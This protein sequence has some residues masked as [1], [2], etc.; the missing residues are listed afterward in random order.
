MK[1]FVKKHWILIIS[2]IY[3]IWP[4]D[5]ISEFFGPIGLVDDAG[6]IIMVLLKEAFSYYKKNKSKPDDNI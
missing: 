1:E 5:L 3:L 2:L 6:F 4:L